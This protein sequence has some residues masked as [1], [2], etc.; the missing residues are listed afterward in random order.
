[1]ISSKLLKDIEFPTARTKRFSLC[2]LTLFAAL[3]SQGLRAQSLAISDAWIKYLPQPIPVRSGYMSVTNDS[4]A[5]ISVTG[6][7]SE[8]FT[9]IEIHE[10]VTK[11]GMMSMQ[12]VLPL[13]ILPNETVNL[14]PGGYHL[15]MMNP[16]RQ[17][18]P[19]DQ[20]EV[21]LHFEDGQS[22]PLQMTVKE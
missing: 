1:M 21:T 2:V 3:A 4:A 16:V 11:D 14:A 6:V 15:M 9:R 8:V 13:D 17:I 18:N 5:V 19:G 7:E 20:V 10:T 12:P 22:Q